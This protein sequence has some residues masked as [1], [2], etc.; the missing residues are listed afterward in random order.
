MEDSIDIKI[1]KKDFFS[2]V[3]NF[4]L[5]LLVFDPMRES[6]DF[7]SLN[8]VISLFRD[9]CIFF[10]FF[11]VVLLKEKKRF[12]ICLLLIFVSLVILL[13]LSTFT[14][15]DKLKNLGFVYGIS[16]SFFMCYVIIN[17][18]GFYKY[19]KEF[20]LKYFIKLAVVN[21]LVTLFIYF[22]KPD[23]ITGRK[24]E[25]R[26]SVGNPSMQSILFICS[27]VL[28]FYFQP[29]PNKIINILF[30]IM[31]LLAVTFT[32]TSTAFIAL[33]VFFVLTFFNKK[34][35]RVWLILGLVICVLGIFAINLLEIDFSKILGLFRAKY[36]EV[37]LIFSKY[38]GVDTNVSTQYKSFSIRETQISNFVENLTP[39]KLF[40]G[41]GIFSMIDQKKYMIENTYV[42][43]IKDF[44]LFGFFI[45][46]VILL[47]ELKESFFVYKKNK[48]YS[49]FAILAIMC[50][51]AITLYIFASNSMTIQFYFALSIAKWMDNDI[52]LNKKFSREYI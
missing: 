46:V 2:F 14:D 22:I 25:L 35:T 36:R 39:I 16:R 30:S 17:L 15:I 11:Y 45:F 5:I 28:C 20:L 49:S 23:L 18:P 52:K 41:D 34:Y 4:Y 38:L 26:L 32:V 9:M 40:F 33:G 24:I 29:F 1:H 37:V 3:F 6:L 31:L 12:S 19:D 47:K 13:I 44:G 10:L 43:L 7:G 50:V 27:F 21:F 42:A 48:K 51:Y 8:T